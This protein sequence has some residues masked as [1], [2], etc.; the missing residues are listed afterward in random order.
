M[1]EPTKRPWTL[2]KLSPDADS[3]EVMADF[4]GPQRSVVARVYAWSGDG[5]V[6]DHTALRERRNAEA[7][8]N[9]ELIA[10]AV[11][12]HDD[13]VEA[14]KVV[15][16]IWDK[17]EGMYCGSCA[18]LQKHGHHVDCRV[19]KALAKAKGESHA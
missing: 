19:A 10:R 13:L 1:T 12:A 5:R 11:N 6:D 17:W 15:E 7:W 8:A 2:A 9:A 18:V 16:W 14:L 3:A 4:G